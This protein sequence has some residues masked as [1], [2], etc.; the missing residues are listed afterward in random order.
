[1]GSNKVDAEMSDMLVDGIAGLEGTIRDTVDQ[2]VK[3]EYH[4]KHMVCSAQQS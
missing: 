1:M 2:A 3:G 4:S